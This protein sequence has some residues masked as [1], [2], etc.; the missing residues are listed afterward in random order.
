MLGKMHEEM[1]Q[2][3]PVEGTFAVKKETT[4]KWRRRR[5]I[6]RTPCKNRSG[7][8]MRRQKQRM[9]LSDL[10]DECGKEQDAVAKSMQFMSGAFSRWSTTALAT[11]SGVRDRRHNEQSYVEEAIATADTLNACIN[12]DEQC[13]EENNEEF[14][15]A[16]KEE[17]RDILEAL[18]RSSN[19]R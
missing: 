18:S 11:I 4:K 6:W 8:H 17:S 15:E 19:G 13:S 10:G 5:K 2:N 9:G 14:E 12:G 16:Q 1:M 7:S 3:E